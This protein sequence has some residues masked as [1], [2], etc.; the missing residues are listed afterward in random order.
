[1]SKI[2][3]LL[4]EEKRIAAAEGKEWLERKFKQSGIP[5]TA[6]NI[7]QISNYFRFPNSL[8]MFYAIATEQFDKSRLD[9]NS[10]FHKAPHLQPSQRHVQGKGPRK[11]KL[12]SAETVLFGD[13]QDEMEYAFAKCCN[14][15]PGDEI[16]GFITVG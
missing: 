15:I 10:I 4:K 11:T 12:Y 8:D 13:H 3:Q 2:K 7:N 5:F 14:P 6:D 1:K 16:V 9:L